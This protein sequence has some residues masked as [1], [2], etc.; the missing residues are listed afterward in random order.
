MTNYS[1]LKNTIIKSSGY[2]EKGSNSF[3]IK[4]TKL[5]T[6]A[7]ECNLRPIIVPTE[8]KHI[9]VEDVPL[10]VE[11]FKG[12][13]LSGLDED[14]QYIL[15]SFVCEDAIDERCEELLKENSVSSISAIFAEYPCCQALVIS[16]M[17]NEPKRFGR[18]SYEIKCRANSVAI[19]ANIS[20]KK[21]DE[22]VEE[23]ESEIE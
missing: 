18:P 19:K 3:F 6:L 7:K 21:N 13:K 9:T 15:L 20:E 1:I 12:N 16:Y 14:K 17:S 10:M 23:Q 4:A 8:S 5:E 11:Y 22:V 2:T